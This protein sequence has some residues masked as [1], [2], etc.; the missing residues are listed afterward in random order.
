MPVKVAV[1]GFGQFGRLHAQTLDALSETQLVGIVDSQQ[2]AIEH[3]SRQFPHVCRWIELERALQEC[4]AEAWVV[5]TSTASHLA[6][7]KA[8]LGAGRAV[9]VEKPLACSLAEAESL[10]PLVPEDSR[11]LMLAHIVLFNSE[12]R[13][14]AEEVRQRGRL[15]YVNC[16]RHRPATTQ[17]AFPGESPLQL[18]MIHD[19]YCVQALTGGAEPTGFSGHLHVNSEGACDLAVVQLTWPD[20]LIA[21]LTA[22]FLTPSGMPTDGFDR[23]EVFGDGWASRI[24]S[25]PRPI[26][27]WDD[28]PRWPLTLEI[29]AGKADPSGMLAEELRAFS[30]VVRGE[31]PV[32]PG[33]RYGDGLQVQRWLAQLETSGQSVKAQST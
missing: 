19:L 22:S 30:R 6:V 21:S 1:V 2:Q 4:D 12:F 5:A 10:A 9:L 14:L 29:R 15:I 7:A 26:E 11:N 17:Q 23:M 8:V 3:A 24:Q 16:V 33:T 25:N 20:G 13:Q 28:R 27:L 31:Q 32:P 18:T